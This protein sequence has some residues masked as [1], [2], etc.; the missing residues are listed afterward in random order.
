MQFI[1]SIQNELPKG[2]PENY[3]AMFPLT[4]CNNILKFL[5]TLEDEK[6]DEIQII[7]A[8]H[9]NDITEEYKEYFYH[10]SPDINKYN[11]LPNILEIKCSDIFIKKIN[12]IKNEKLDSVQYLINRIKF[13][14]YSELKDI[15]KGNIKHFIYLAYANEE[16]KAAIKEFSNCII[17]ADED[18]IKV[19]LNS[20]L[21][22]FDKEE[23]LEVENILDNIKKE[24]NKNNDLPYSNS[25][26]SFIEIFGDDLL[27]QLGS[28]G[29]RKKI[30]IKGNDIYFVNK[31]IYHIVQPYVPT[32]YNLIHNV[33]VETGFNN[34]IAF[35]NFDF[36]Q[37]EPE[38][39]RKLSL[40]INDI[41]EYFCILQSRNKYPNS[42]YDLYF[43]TFTECNLPDEDKI[44]KYITSIF[45]SF[46]IEQFKVNKEAHLLALLHNNNL[47]APF[48]KEATNLQILNKITSKIKE[49]KVIELINNVGFWCYLR[50]EISEINSKENLYKEPILKKQIKIAYDSPNWVLIGLGKTI[51]LTDSIQ[52]K[53]VAI[54]YLCLILQSH[55]INKRSI[56]SI[57]LYNNAMEITGQVN[58]IKTV[59]NKEDKYIIKEHCSNAIRNTINRIK[60]PT[61]KNFF[62]EYISFRQHEYYF[63]KSMDFLVS[64]EHPMIKVN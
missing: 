34:P 7:Y 33:P 50:R 64:I 57:D 39:C 13:F 28:L 20:K 55:V 46:L 37:D 10:F 2:C 54:I 35:L 42:V 8:L 14:S 47:L 6:L 36:I 30:H 41:N 53:N 61:I 23:Y 22:Y 16:L 24:I 43:S 11:H 38:K 56:S 63:D 58:N 1:Y 4:E 12:E 62:A 59:S 45:I 49:I 5:L 26:P 18:T 25:F 19:P 52:N 29:R 40:L 15:P 31:V 44:K 21:Y 60:N 51:H 27:K 9:S 17:A 3:F 48:L 32:L